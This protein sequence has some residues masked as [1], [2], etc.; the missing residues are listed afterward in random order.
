MKMSDLKAICDEADSQGLGDVQVRIGD[1]SEEDEL[2]CSVGRIVKRND[3]II[4]VPGDDDVWK[5]ET[6]AS[7]ILSQQLWPEEEE[8]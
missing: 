1:V 3:C 2:H 4:L 7:T 5:D 6:V 8:G